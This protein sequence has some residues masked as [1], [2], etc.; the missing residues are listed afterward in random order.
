[1]PLSQRRHF[2]TAVLYLV[3]WATREWNPIFTRLS[4]ANQQRCVRP[5]ESAGGCV[6]IRRSAFAEGGGM[7]SGRLVFGKQG[8]FF[9][10]NATSF[11][12][13]LTTK[14]AVGFMCANNNLGRCNRWSR[15]M[16]VWKQAH[17]EGSLIRTQGS[18]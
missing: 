16:L 3:H 10:N 13:Y 2:V 17:K 7:R 6:P 4:R 18:L 9:F 1:M 15:S 8:S 5:V 11:M 12:L 14:K